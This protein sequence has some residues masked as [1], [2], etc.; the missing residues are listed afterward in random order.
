[1]F[2]VMA[3][4]DKIVN[5]LNIESTF[6]KKREEATQT[7]TRRAPHQVVFMLPVVSL[8]REIEARATCLT[9]GLQKPRNKAGGSA[10]I[11]DAT[12]PST[13]QLKRT[14]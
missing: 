8:A 11:F 5:S 12:S 9:A 14:Q 3:T 1:M 10:V 7:K 2:H 6:S 13:E 4:S